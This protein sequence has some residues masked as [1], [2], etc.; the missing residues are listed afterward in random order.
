M[1]YIGYGYAVAFWNSFNRDFNWKK[2]QNSRKVDTIARM[3]D[4]QFCRLD[5]LVLWEKGS[6]DFAIAD[7][8]CY[9]LYFAYQ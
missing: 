5:Y 6:V 8:E 4:W 1:L 3:V 7:F 9:L 2:L